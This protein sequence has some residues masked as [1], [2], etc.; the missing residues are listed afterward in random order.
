VNK[1][2]KKLEQENELLKKEN[3]LLKEALDLKEPD[4]FK[5]L[6]E[7]ENKKEKKKYTKEI[8]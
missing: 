4:K 3:K 1:S 2:I 8:D 6:K 7:P 5:G